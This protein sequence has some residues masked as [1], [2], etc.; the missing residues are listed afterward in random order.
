VNRPSQPGSVVPRA[1]PPAGRRQPVWAEAA[2]WSWVLL[3]L[4][5]FFSQT[6]P[7]NQ[8]VTRL[9]VA[10][11]APFTLMDAV[12]PPTGPGS[13][14]RG[15]QY[16]P[17]RLPLW[18]TAALLLAGAW[19][20]GQWLLW[21]AGPWSLTRGERF[22]FAGLMGLSGLSLLILAGGLAGIMS[23]WV[24]RTAL[25][26]L[27]ASGRFVSSRSHVPHPSAASTSAASLL[28][29]NGAASRSPSQW[30]DTFSQH[31]GW[32]AAAPFVLAIAL[33]S[34][35]PSTDFD[36][37]EYHLGG[38][39][40]WFLQGQIT[41]LPHNIYTSFPFLTE[42][43]LLGGM[44]VHG[45]WYWGGIA[46]QVVLAAFAPLTA[47]GLWT[48]GLRWSSPRVANLSVLIYLTTPWI[49]RLS[50]I[51]Y[52]EGG[53]A[54]YCAGTALATLLALQQLRAA[55]PEP[56]W[57]SADDG[58][59]PLLVT[60]FLAGS[61]FACKYPGLL[62]AVFPVV[63]LLSLA[64][65]QRIRELRSKPV[66]PAGEANSPSELRRGWRVRRL[67]ATSGCFA[68][69]ATIAVGPW[70]LK[71]TVETGNPVYP[72]GYAVFGGVDLTPEL[73][74]KFDRGHARPSAGSWRGE[75]RDFVRK[76]IDVAMINDWQSPLIAAFLPWLWGVAGDRKALRLLIGFTAWQ[77]VVWW[78]FTH[79]LDRFWLPLLPTAALLA[80]MAIDAAWSAQRLAKSAIIGLLAMCTVYHLA[81]CTSGMCGYNVGLTDL[82]AARRFTAQ[83]TSPDVLWLN[84][85]LRSDNRLASAKV[86]CVGEAQL[87][88]AEF[89]YRYNTVFDA[90]LFEQWCSQPTT[91]RPT[92]GQPAATWPLRPAE[93][94]RQK[95]QAEGIT[96]L[97]VNWSEILRYRP[98]YGYP[99]FVRPAHFLTLVEQGVLEP[100]LPRPTPLGRRR[101]NSLQPAERQQLLSWG[102][103]LLLPGSNSDEQE[104][105]SGAIYRVV[106]AT[107]DS[108]QHEGVP[109]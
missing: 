98:T 60:G 71:N 109:R 35:S 92:T 106:P 79:H 67:M 45:D 37:K 16:L 62:Q 104:F 54:A 105:V 34:V 4:W 93:E 78:G 32:W 51:A 7:N 23:P 57:R 66:L 102:P 2:R 22:Y 55:G 76:A 97:L 43:L 86:L 84:D 69:A 108:T 20:L 11:S 95:L 30:T 56:K 26:A 83:I 75:L 99:D 103:E 65:L 6:L 50:I 27:A 89:E 9:E 10:Q 25:L 47:W 17:Q 44:L 42:M 72:L 12:D 46:G 14:P 29:R 8:P 90:S 53:L 28:S 13:L 1:E 107:Q 15:W 3:F 85:E 36:V 64:T 77:F 41:F 18:G 81:F 70:L 61:A 87:F 82:N 100:P 39:K 31:W 24:W 38:P 49:Y 94:I 91:G 96:H 80:A 59:A 63:P 21:L 52:V 74:D 40:E 88:D 5:L 68:I 33:G 101:V 48:A 19:G 73:A 58:V